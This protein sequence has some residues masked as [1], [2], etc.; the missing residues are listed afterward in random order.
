MS[1]WFKQYPSSASAKLRIFC[2]PY[3]GGSAQVF[4][5]WANKIPYPVDLFVL[6]SPGRGR[7]FNEKPIAC[8]STKVQILHREILPYTTLPY[9]FI[10]HSNGA[11][12]AYELARELQKSGNCHLQHIVLSA[13]RAPHLPRI[14]EPI[15]QLPGPEF[16]ARLKDYDYTP[17]EV[18][19]NQ[20]FMELFLPML[21]ADFALSD[22]H[23]FVQ[24]HPL[25]S[26][27]SLFWGQQDKDVPLA[28]V[29]AWRE[30]LVGKTE[31]VEFNAGHFF[32]AS[33]EEQFIQHI[34]Q[35]IETLLKQHHVTTT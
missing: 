35:L 31:L 7:R 23:Q 33:H 28:D 9:I 14:R 4:S 22:T 29:L 24:K 8:L 11:L 13:K 20:E 3:A 32:I 5:K 6:Q 34:N 17:D 10:G 16:L 26:D 25:Q 30:L 1:E 12:L 15:H 19:E 2:F 27:A 18:L 21:R